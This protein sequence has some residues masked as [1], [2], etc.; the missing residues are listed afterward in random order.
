MYM[1]QYVLCTCLLSIFI[2]CRT[3]KWGHAVAQWVEALRY[4]PKSRGFDSRWYHW[5]FLLTQ[6][7]RLQYGPRVDSASYSRNISWGVTVASAW[8][9]QPLLTVLKSWSLNLLEPSGPV[10][11]CNG[12]ALL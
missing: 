6:T 8:S 1:Y 5:N 9:R 4:K 2:Y 12:I 11:P 3:R 10:Q 7:F